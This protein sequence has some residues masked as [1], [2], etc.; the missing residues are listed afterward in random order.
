MAFSNILHGIRNI[1][2]C[3]RILLALSVPVIV[4][5]AFA[6]I[7]LTED[8]RQARESDRVRNLAEL[9]PSISNL[10][11]ELQKE[12]GASAGFIGSKGA[13]FSDILKAQRGDTDRMLQALR[14]ELG[15][16]DFAAYDATMRGQVETANAALEKLQASRDNIDA[17][18]FSVGDMAGYYSPTIADLLHIVEHMTVLST[19]A[20]I[21][22]KI[23]AYTAFME[24][25]ERAGIERAMGSAGFAA[26]TFSPAIFNKL[27]SLI[28]QQDAFFDRFTVLAPE[29]ILTIFKQTVAGKPVEDIERMRK[30]AIDSRE[31]GSTQGIDATDWFQT[32]TDRINQLKTVENTIASD[33]VTSA[34]TLIAAANR[35]LTV[36]LTSVLAVLFIGGL[37]VYFSI[38]SITRPVS[39]MTSAMLALAEGDTEA[40]IPAVGQKD[41]IGQMAGAVQVFRENTIE[42]ERLQAE[43]A[44]EEAAEH[45]RQRR[46]EALIT[47]FRD[48]VGEVTQ[49]VA[50]NTDE[51]EATARSLS[52]IA[53]ETHAQA[54]SVSAASEE[55]SVNVQTVAQAT[56]ELASSITE[57][58]N[59]ISQT[60]VVVDKASAATDET[61]RKVG[62]LA[63]AA[64]KIGEVISLIQNIAEQTNLLAL[65][66]TIEAARAG[67]AGKGFAIVASEV[68]DLAT[69]T[70]KATEAIDG[71][72]TGIQ[73]ETD[74]SV[75]AI[76]TIAETMT[77]VTGATE[78]IAA[79]V[80][81]QSAS[82]AEI[83]NNVQQAAIGSGEVSQNICGVSDAAD[84]TQT[85]ADQ[86]L[87]SAQDMSKIANRLRGIVD[88]F[89]D[90]VAA[91]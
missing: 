82:T 10:V 79:A 52:S 27:V 66:A 77:E 83:A 5:V 39:G 62:G 1:S 7:M 45:E 37:V 91:A 70:A 23:A 25:K 49:I 74:S 11:H 54:T 3:S 80:E 89:L 19:D 43:R 16:F 13:K 14:A 67:E 24:A 68:K 76:R 75:D 86:V 42:R 58:A 57:V 6:G 9:A 32:A 65:N 15:G 47:D 22:K 4:L 33:L 71:F 87:N 50:A 40:P 29:K 60:K 18:K 55:A 20:A 28:A 73:R 31:S 72:I 63:D 59:Q 2:V 90:E 46:I 34:E 53:T 12:R 51:L 17:F 8:W 35:R 81:E 64:K 61:V 56:E 36:A 48:K 69:Q 21:T 26:G 78:A 38:I 85:S 88:T 84:Q 41:E 30:I 44:Q